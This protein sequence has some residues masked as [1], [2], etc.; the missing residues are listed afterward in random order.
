MSASPSPRWGLF[1]QIAGAYFLTV[2][3]IIL[4]SCNCDDPVSLESVN[5]PR[6]RRLTDDVAD[7]S[8]S[9]VPFPSWRFHDQKDFLVVDGV[10][11]MFIL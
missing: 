1:E 11:W 7:L 3:S 6:T 5:S 10:G 8:C 2:T 9:P 4:F